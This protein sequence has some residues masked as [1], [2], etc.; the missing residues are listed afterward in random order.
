MSYVPP[1]TGDSASQPTPYY[2]DD[3]PMTSHARPPSSSGSAG[4]YYRDPQ[5]TNYTQE[6]PIEEEDESEDEDVFAYLP[7]TTAEQVTEREREREDQERR[8]RELLDAA[9]QE[10]PAESSR[11]IPSSPSPPQPEHPLNM[12]PLTPPAPTF[13]PHSRTYHPSNPYHPTNFNSAASPTSAS[14][15]VADAPFTPPFTHLPVESPPST[16]SQPDSDNPYR[17]RRVDSGVLTP[18]TLPPTTG[19]AS[20]GPPSTG[21]LS[22]ARRR[23]ASKGVHVDLPR[24]E[25]DRPQSVDSTGVSVSAMG[26]TNVS[27][28]PSMMDFVDS[29]SREGSIKCVFHFFDGINH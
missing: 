4:F 19:N 3:R 28:T 13:D 8:R 18:S 5:Y 26:S 20:V 29:E 9:L 6:G 10:K 25:K 17:M 7:P 21:R 16:S 2:Y 23:A 15:F 14:P 1:P 27:M 22:L 12:P 24:N 11:S